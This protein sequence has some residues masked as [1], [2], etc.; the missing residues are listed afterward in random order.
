M[1]ILKND[2][3]NCQEDKRMINGWA[4]F[5]ILVALFYIVDTAVFLKGYNTFFWCYKT[6][7]ELAS[8]KKKLGI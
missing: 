8:Q 2:P 6:E 7:N 1:P 4:I 3:K 5:W